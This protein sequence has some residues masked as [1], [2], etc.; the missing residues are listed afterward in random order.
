MMPLKKLDTNLLSL[1]NCT[2][3]A[4]DNRLIIFRSYLEH[5]VARGT[6]TED[7]ISL[8]FNFI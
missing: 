3:S 7:R 1:E 2:Y 4:V 6:N 5:M 8:S